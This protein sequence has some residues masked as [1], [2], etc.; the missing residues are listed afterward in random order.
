ML[1]SI[2][3]SL[4]IDGTDLDVEVQDLIEAAVLDLSIAGVDPVKL[5]TPDAL[6]KRAITVYCK[7][8]FGYDDPRVAERF[9]A[10]YLSLKQHLTLSGEYMAGD[11]SE[12]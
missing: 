7:A 4:R 5:A 9:E 2:K 12:S 3:N 11:A 6:L 10:S 1:E 8:N